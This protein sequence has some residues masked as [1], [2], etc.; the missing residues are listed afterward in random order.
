MVA[1]RSLGDVVIFLALLLAVITPQRSLA[2]SD[3]TGSATGPLMCYYGPN[4]YVPC[5][6]PLLPGHDPLE[7]SV[8]RYAAVLARLRAYPSVSFNLPEPSTT[9]TAEELSQDAGALFVTVAFQLDRLVMDSNRLARRTQENES[10]LQT[11]YARERDLQ[12]RGEALPA[13]LREANANLAL[14]QATAE[15]KE[16]LV[17]SVEAV[18]DRMHARAD[19]AA[20]ESMQWLTVASPPGV[21]L[22]TEKMVANRNRSKRYPLSVA[23]EVAYPRASPRVIVPHAEFPP[24][25]RP[26]PIGT[27]DDKIAATEALI[28][29]IA[30]VSAQYEERG[31]R[32]DKLERVLESVTPRV[33]VLE[34]AVGGGEESLQAVERLMSHA[35]SRNS[36][37]YFNRIT[38]GGNAALAIGEAYIMETF[39]D[40]VVKPEVLRFLRANGIM[41]KIDSNLVVQLYAQRKSLLP[42][43]APKQWA[44]LGR[45]VEVEKRAI[46]LMHDIETYLYAAIES[47]SSPNDRNAAPLLE[48]VR[49]GTGTAGRELIEKAADDP[50]L[51][52]KIAH[53]M[54]GRR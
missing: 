24:A 54:F 45:L 4:Q 19:V 9:G 29:Q 22:V 42:P 48:E 46:Q 27:A 7:L 34:T 38:A 20:T 35:E 18:A 10:F 39:R 12:A 30:E 15:A 26:A 11:L 40:K 31:S 47:I 14:E 8:A 32:Y 44:A 17:N 37:A 25:H 52:Y 6:T 28:P 2:Q 41:Q 16:R 51:G 3:P 13:V 21:P 43:L 1:K 36:M 23:I 53:A 50:G 5:S 49:A 33:K